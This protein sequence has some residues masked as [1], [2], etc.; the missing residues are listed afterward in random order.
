MFHIG[1]HGLRAHLS[2]FL[3]LQFFESTVQL[4]ETVSYRGN[5]IFLAVRGRDKPLIFKRVYTFHVYNRVSKFVH[6]FGSSKGTFSGY[7]ELAI[8]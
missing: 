7:G 4:K 2:R 6:F 8:I 1:D 3:R 5:T